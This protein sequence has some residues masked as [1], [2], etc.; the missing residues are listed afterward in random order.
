MR[1]E[2]LRP[3]NIIYAEDG[4]TILSDIPFSDA[5]WDAWDQANTVREDSLEIIEQ[6]KKS[7]NPEIAA[8]AEAFSNLLNEG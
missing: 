4:V 1:D 2:S 3:H 7:K 5:E 8:L 6:A